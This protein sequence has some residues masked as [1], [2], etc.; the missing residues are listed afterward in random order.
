VIIKEYLCLAHGDFEAGE[1]KCPCGCEGDMMVQRVFRTAPSIQTQGYRNTNATFESLAREHGLSD[2]DNS[3]GGGMR[4]ADAATR[5]RL[6]KATEMVAPSGRDVNE[7]FADVRTRNQ[8]SSTAR[9]V[10]EVTRQSADTTAH[11]GA[12]IKNEAGGI[13]LSNGVELN[14][15][16]VRIEG[17][18][19]GRAS[20]GL[21]AGDA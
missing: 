11:G 10:G 19:D 9:P 21:P 14:R 4:L 6:A 7:Y 5:H 15:P 1:P 20:A 18:F 3:D 8:V 17:R 13:S 12:I 16:G 2:M